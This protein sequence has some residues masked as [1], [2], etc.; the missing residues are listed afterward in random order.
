MNKLDILKLERNRLVDAWN[1]KSGDER[2]K[3]LVKIM[4]LDEDINEQ[5][6]KARRRQ[7]TSRVS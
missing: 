3:L 6:S 5:I 7:K 1:Q 2:V 4:D